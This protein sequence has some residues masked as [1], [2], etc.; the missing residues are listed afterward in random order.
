MGSSAVPLKSITGARYTFMA[1]AG[2]ASISKGTGNLR[3]AGEFLAVVRGRR[4]ARTFA[5]RVTLWSIDRRTPTDAPR[6]PKT[7]LVLTVRVI[8][9]IG[10]CRAGT[11]GKATVVDW[12][13]KLD[14]G[15]TSD[16]VNVRFPAGSCRSLA[17]RWTNVNGGRVRVAIAVR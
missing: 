17:G 5:S 13:R 3:K 8:S 15:K 6:V 11:R 2:A 9:S 14:N 10:G 4:A 1:S 16:R 7:T 12:N